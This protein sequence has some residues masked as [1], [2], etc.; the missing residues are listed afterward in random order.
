M[1]HYVSRLIAHVD[2]TLDTYCGCA[3]Q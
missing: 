1:N 3:G 2:V